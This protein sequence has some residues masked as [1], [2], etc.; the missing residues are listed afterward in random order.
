MELLE[1]PKYG[2]VGII[3]A[4]IGAVIMSMKLYHKMATNHINH[5]NDAFD[6]TKDAINENTVVL[7]K[8][9]DSMETNAR[10]TERLIDKIDR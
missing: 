9:C 1:L 8:V 5:S 3:I 10:V 6:R 7:T 2:T 4:L